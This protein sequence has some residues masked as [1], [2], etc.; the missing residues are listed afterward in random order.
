[1]CKKVREGARL[2]KVPGIGPIT[3]ATVASRLVERSFP[4]S[5]SF[6]AYCGLDVA[7][8]QS[9]QKRG[10]YGLT[11]QGDAELRRLLYLCAQSSVRAKNS[12]FKAH[13]EREQ[14]KGLSKTA[15]LC[16]V[17]RKM[18]RLCWS[19]VEHNQSYDPDRVY[20]QPKQSPNS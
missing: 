3:A 16:A 1:M 10:N 12:P 14:A 9:G 8:K 18:A 17:A 4:H 19:L 13:Y 20:Q 11:K 2:E 6:V 5:D 15:A 7:I